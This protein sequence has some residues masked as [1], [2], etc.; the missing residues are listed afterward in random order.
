MTS[1]HGGEIS[2]QKAG[3]LRLITPPAC[4]G[5][6]EAWELSRGAQGP[7]LGP[8]RVPHFGWVSEF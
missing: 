3:I 5:I 7:A 8:D 4:M 6:G 2:G 1:N